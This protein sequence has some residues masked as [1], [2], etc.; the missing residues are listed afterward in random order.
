MKGGRDL[1]VGTGQ[2]V[3]KRGLHRRESSHMTF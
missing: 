2:V 1:L 3:G